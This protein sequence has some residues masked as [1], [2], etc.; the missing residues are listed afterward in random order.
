MSN[1]NSFGQ[2]GSTACFGISACSTLKVFIECLTQIYQG[3]DAD[4]EFTLTDEEGQPINV[5]DV[6]GIFIRL[7]GDKYSYM[8]FV[9]PDT[10][11]TFPI[12]ILQHEENNEQVDVGIFSIQIPAEESAKFMTG[13]L[14]AEIKIKIIDTNYPGGYKTKV[15]SCLKLADIKLSQT[16]DIT[17]F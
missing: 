5:N 4:L 11:G 10:T 14:Y 9:W 6:A 16:K 7:Y 2:P 3:A 15:I 1:I 12:N 8:N 13:G 17:D